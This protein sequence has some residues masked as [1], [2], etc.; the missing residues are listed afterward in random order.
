MSW[1][2]D[3]KVGWE[4]REKKEVVRSSRIGQGGEERSWYDQAAAV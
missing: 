2:Q 1:A 4:E 3:M